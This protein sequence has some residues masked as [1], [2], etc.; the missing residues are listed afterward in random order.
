[1]DEVC[2][3][4][5]RR[6]FFKFFKDGLIYRGKRLVNWDTYLQT[7]VADDEVFDEEVEGHF[8]TFTYPVVNEDGKPT[9]KNIA[10]ST[11][12]PE[13]MLGDTAVCVHPSDDRYRN[14]VG[15]KVQ[16]PLNGRLIPIIADAQLADPEMGTGAVKVTPAPRS[17]R[18]RLFPTQ[19]GNW[20]H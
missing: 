7:A 18:L 20:A 8:W 13:T 4:A 15:Q 9:G 12:R 19:P 17:Q 3:K 6:T 5:V 11:T 16:I 1:M 10:F 14:L 2:S